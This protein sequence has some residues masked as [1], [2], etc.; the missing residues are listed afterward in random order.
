M[1]PHNYKTLRLQIFLYGTEN[2]L[3]IYDIDD[4]DPQIQ[5]MNKQSMLSNGETKES[6]NYWQQ[7]QSR[8]KENG[9]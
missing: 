7:L 5:H 2:A 6:S 1:V 3:G 9:I 4:A 8:Y